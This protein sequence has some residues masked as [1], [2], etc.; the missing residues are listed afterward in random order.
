MICPSRVKP[1]QRLPNRCYESITV[2]GSLCLRIEEC[3]GLVEKIGL[4]EGSLAACDMQ[5]FS[6]VWSIHRV[7][8]GIHM[9]ACASEGLS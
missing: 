4:S 7:V 6:M 8:G 2:V 5:T 3:A 9:R 1:K